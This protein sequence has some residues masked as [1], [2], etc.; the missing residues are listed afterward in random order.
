MPC[1]WEGERLAHHAAVQWS[2]SAGGKSSPGGWKDLRLSP[3]LG[4]G[5]ER[6]G[7]ETH[8]QE[9]AFVYKERGWEMSLIL[10]RAGIEPLILGTADPSQ[11]QKEEH[12]EFKA[13]GSLRTSLKGLYSSSPLEWLLLRWCLD[14]CV[15]L[16]PLLPFCCCPA[17]GTQ[18]WCVFVSRAVRSHPTVRGEGLV[19]PSGGTLWL[20]HTRTPLPGL[21]SEPCPAGMRHG[22]SCCC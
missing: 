12:V 22:S 20:M 18:R 15:F 14:G 16:C 6:K 5:E 1:S 13:V 11:C 19:P 21:S 7:R 8:I 3:S 2:C 9:F 17:C 10:W 4:L